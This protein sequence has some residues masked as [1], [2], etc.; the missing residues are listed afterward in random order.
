MCL[1]IYI[2]VY[3]SAYVYTFSFRAVGFDRKLT[4]SV[5]VLLPPP[6]RAESRLEPFSPLFLKKKTSFWAI[7]LKPQKRLTRLIRV[8]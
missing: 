5:A 1:Y 8:I 4:E 2:Y 6:W 3:T 7:S